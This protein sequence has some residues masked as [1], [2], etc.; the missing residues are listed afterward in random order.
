PPYSFYDD[1]TTCRLME[2][3]SLFWGRS[4]W[5]C[6]CLCGRQINLSILNKRKQLG[7]IKF[8]N[9]A[10][11]MICY[12][13]AIEPCYATCVCNAC[14]AYKSKRNLQKRCGSH[15]FCVIF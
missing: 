4:I 15:L 7:V 9:S 3:R 11:K 12:T 2:V 8:T 5:K 14:L 13:P 1:V 6:D 10:Y